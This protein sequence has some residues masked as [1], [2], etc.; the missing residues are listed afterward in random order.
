[1]LEK[2]LIPNAD[3]RTKAAGAQY[4]FASM[5]TDTG[6]RSGFQDGS[7]AWRNP[8]AIDNWGHKAMHGS[9]Q[10]AKSIARA[11]YGSDDKKAD[12]SSSYYSGCSTGGRQG[13]RPRRRLVVVHLVVVPWVSMGHVR[14]PRRRRLRYD[15]V[16]QAFSFE[17]FGKW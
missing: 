12:I 1:M 10:A 4:G 3:M 11:F 5:S 16:H 14:H 8:D 6:H 15:E 9:V 17:T 13:Y 2:L 7:W